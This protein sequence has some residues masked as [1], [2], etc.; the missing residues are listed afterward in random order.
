[1]AISAT[2]PRK[3]IVKFPVWIKG[4]P[5]Q[6]RLRAKAI[7]VFLWQHNSKR[8]L[9]PTEVAVFGR[10]V[11]AAKWPSDGTFPAVS[12]KTAEKL[13][14]NTA[15]WDDWRNFSKLRGLVRGIKKKLH[16]RS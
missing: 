2:L 14:I 7:Y 6:E 8:E 12:S 16:F 10:L 3:S 9:T 15:E 4:L 11:E 1:M 13:G 5:A